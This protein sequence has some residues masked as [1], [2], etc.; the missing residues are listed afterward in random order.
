VQFAGAFGE[1]TT[2]VS[3]VDAARDHERP[4]PQAVPADG[5]AAASSISTGAS[6]S[7]REIAIRGR[8]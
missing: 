5:Q 2:V 7:V 6:A 4:H 1:Q 8:P 3:V